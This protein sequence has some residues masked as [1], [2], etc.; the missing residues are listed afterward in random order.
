MR[1][2]AL[3]AVLVAT[4]PAQTPEETARKT[5]QNVCGTC[6]GIEL[7]KGQRRTRAAWVKNVDDMAAKGA[8]ASDED[9][10]IVVEYLVRNYGKVNVN[11]AEPAE[12]QIVLGL[13]PKQSA[14]IVA[15]RSKHGDITDTA[16]LAKAA[17]VPVQQM[18]QIKDRILF[19]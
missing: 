9:F 8:Q 11:R 7:M 12:L 16:T 2:L 6:H 18:D 5:F 19:R 1:S 4:L 13:N 10:A 17:A 14:A 3:L 15:H